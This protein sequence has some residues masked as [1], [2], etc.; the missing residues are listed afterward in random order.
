MEGPDPLK[1]YVASSWRNARQ[2]TVVA[3]L[4]EAGHEVYD[5]R[6]PAPGNEGF[7]W[8]EI[9][10]AWKTW[11]PEQYREALGHPVADRG[12]ELD[13]QG[14][15]ESDACVLVM[16]CGRSAHLEAGWFAGLGRP[17]V[18]L[19]DEAFEPELMYKLTASVCLSMEEV[20][21]IL[22]LFQC[23]VCGC[24]DARACPGGCGWVEP[25]LCSSCAIEQP[26]ELLVVGRG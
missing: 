8:S 23:R 22:A 19:L 12:F 10:P 13:L 1:L 11:T 21:R 18:V 6:H 16:P 24:T 25:G 15:V 9:D 4:R 26:A 3:E 14:M 20:L 5:F 17:V 7:H 2:P